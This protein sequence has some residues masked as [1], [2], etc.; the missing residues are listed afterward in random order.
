MAPSEACE[1]GAE[2]LI[3]DHVIF[4]CPIHRSTHGMHP[5]MVLADETKE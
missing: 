3:V 4:H 2:E 5:L 1:C